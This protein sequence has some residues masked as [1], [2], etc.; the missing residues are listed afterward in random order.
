MISSQVGNNTQ[1][2]TQDKQFTLIVE[3]A[4]N[5]VNEQ[6]QKSVISITIT[7]SELSLQGVANIIQ[8][9][10]IFNQQQLT[11]VNNHEAI[12]LSTWSPLAVVKK[13]L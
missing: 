13:Q 2:Q 5:E 11:T 9:M 6:E 4:E 7:S 8:E 12:S 10:A 3:M 1:Y